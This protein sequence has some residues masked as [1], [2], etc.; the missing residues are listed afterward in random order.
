MQRFCL[1]RHWGC[2]RAGICLPYAT[3][4]RSA[5]VSSWS[6][7]QLEV[8]MDFTSLCKHGSILSLPSAVLP[9]GSIRAFPGASLQSGDNQRD[10]WHVPNPS[11]FGCTKLHPVPVLPWAPHPTL[12]GMCGIQ[13]TRSLCCGHPGGCPPSPLMPHGC[14]LLLW[15]Q[16]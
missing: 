8:S 1:P 11:L 9:P 7:S 16:N 10:I 12:Q 13:R 3:G 6:Q 4:T 5:Q 15:E 2:A 14:S